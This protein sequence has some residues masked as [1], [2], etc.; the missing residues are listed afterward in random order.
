MNVVGGWK[1]ISHSKMRKSF[2]LPIITY[3]SVWIHNIPQI[4]FR[5]LFQVF[6][7]SFFVPQRT[8]VWIITIVKEQLLVLADVSDGHSTWYGSMSG[9]GEEPLRAVVVKVVIHLVTQGS[10]V[11]VEVY[12]V[13]RQ[14]YPL[15]TAVI[16]VDKDLVS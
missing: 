12:Q 13:S 6:L 7:H 16:S 8:I 3:Q 5:I 9:V 14:V 10:R 4:I 15:P 11:V 2:I 1:M